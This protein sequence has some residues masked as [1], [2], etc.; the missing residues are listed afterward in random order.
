MQLNPLITIIDELADGNL[1]RF[2]IQKNYWVNTLTWRSGN[3]GI[4][5]KMSIRA[6]PFLLNAKYSTARCCISTSMQLSYLRE[7]KIIEVR[8]ITNT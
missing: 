4:S 6:A 3:L 2:F 7:H 5:A 1:E 8:R